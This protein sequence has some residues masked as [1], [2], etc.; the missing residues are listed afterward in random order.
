[1]RRPPNDP[2]VAIIST[3]MT[4]LILFYG[5]LIS[6]VTLGAFTWTLARDGGIAKATTMSFLT[7]SLAQLFHLGNARSSQPV[8]S[9]P[10]ITR[11]PYALG[12]VAL[13]LLLQALA[14]N[15]PV[16]A[17]VLGTVPLS[18]REWLIATA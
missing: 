2:S 7:L 3:R 15:L 11:N 8:V 18:P 10:A 12:A 5:A 13:T 9:L 4:W 17:R 6:A 14:V 16:L 1:M